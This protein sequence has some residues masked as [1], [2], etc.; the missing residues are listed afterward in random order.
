MLRDALDD[1]NEHIVARIGADRAGFVSITPPG[2]G[3]DSIGQVHETR[4]DALAV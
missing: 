1:V 2:A 3:R 4:G